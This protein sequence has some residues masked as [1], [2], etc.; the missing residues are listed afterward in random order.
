M[1][2]LRSILAAA[3]L[4]LCLYGASASAQT[5][6]LEALDDYCSGDVVIKRPWA[7][8]PSLD[9]GDIVLARSA[10]MC[11]LVQQQ[12]HEGV[13]VNAAT[14]KSAF[15]HYIAYNTIRNP[16]DRRVRWFCGL[17]AE[18]LR[19]EQGTKFLRARLG[20]DRLLRTEC[21]K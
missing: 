8:G 1:E 20:P 21:W 16:A 5:H 11:R 15:T 17:T 19:C 9:D 13:C 2:D 18:R 3:G 14:G 6:K 4:A 12:T 7:N 10:T